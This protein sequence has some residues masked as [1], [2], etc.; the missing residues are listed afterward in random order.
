MPDRTAAAWRNGWFHT[1]DGFRRDAAGEYW[2]VDRI[3][4]SLRRRGENVSSFELEAF[5]NEHEAVAECAAIGVPGDDG[6]QEIKIVVVARDGQ[7][8]DPEHLVDFIAQR[9]P[10]FMVPRFVEVV[11]SLP[12][13]DA[14]MRVKKEDL[15]RAGNS[16][17]TWDRLAGASGRVGA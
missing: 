9:A 2:F 5:V 15:R 1:G 6:E 12:K 17:R 10:R 11:D 16:D 13:T 3:K 7:L 4:D 8:V 14:T